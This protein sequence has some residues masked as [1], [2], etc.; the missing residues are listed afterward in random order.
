MSPNRYFTLL[1]VWAWEQTSQALI[2]GEPH[3]SLCICFNQPSSAWKIQELKNQTSFSI[4]SMELCP[5]HFSFRGRGGT[6]TGMEGEW[7]W[8]TKGE[9][10][11]LIPALLWGSPEKAPGAKCACAS[12]QSP[13]TGMREAGPKEHV[14]RWN[15]LLS[16]NPNVILIWA[17]YMYIKGSGVPELVRNLVRKIRTCV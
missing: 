7:A 14:S 4:S 9:F 2:A 16:Q 12:S 8:E 1:A 10:W 17:H 3:D 5:Q 6:S 15:S 11:L 13:S